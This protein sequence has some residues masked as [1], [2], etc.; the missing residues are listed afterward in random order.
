M[1]NGLRLRDGTPLRGGGSSAL[2]DMER[3]ES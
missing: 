3:S 2:T 1:V